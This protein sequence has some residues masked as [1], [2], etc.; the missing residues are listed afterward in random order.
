MRPHSR[1]SVG[2]NFTVDFTITTEYEAECPDSLNTQVLKTFED[3]KR[4][5]A[6]TTPSRFGNPHLSYV[7]RTKLM[8]PSRKLAFM[9]DAISISRSEGYYFRHSVN[10][11]LTIRYSYW[12]EEFP[13]DRK[14]LLVSLKGENCVF[15]MYFWIKSRARASE[16]RKQH[17]EGLSSYLCRW[18]RTWVGNSFVQQFGGQA[19]G[20]NLLLCWAHD[21]VV[22]E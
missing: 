8:K 15:L 11:L 12:L 3:K 2:Q 10:Y 17:E 13:F 9:W 19:W 22:L 21:G 20:G 5:L 14:I 6:A 1:R 7:G 16:R 18:W 4:L